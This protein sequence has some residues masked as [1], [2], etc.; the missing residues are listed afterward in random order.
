MHPVIIT[1]SKISNSVWGK[2]WC[3]HLESFSDYENRLPRGRSYVR[4]GSVIDLKISSAKVSAMVQGSS[5]Y[6]V[7]VSIMNVSQ[8]KWKRIVSEC[9][10][11]I[12]SVM[13]LL[14]GR[15]SSSIMTRMT[16][17]NDGLFPLLKE[18]SLKCSCPDRVSMCKHVAATLYGVGARLDIEPELLFVL[19][20]VNHA[21]LIARTAAPT[22]KIAKSKTVK[23]TDLAGIFG[24]D[25][26]TTSQQIPK[27]LKSK[28]ATSKKPKNRRPVPKKSAPKSKLK[29]HALQS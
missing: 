13:E 27:Q 18:I 11:K 8:D 16:D 1:G 25:I 29:L 7:T 12:A 3:K 19:R 6:D 2:A 14:Q 26:E 17:R 5:L 20:G 15:L 28:K 10:S 24:I 23:E 22:T 21:D 9:S 4:H